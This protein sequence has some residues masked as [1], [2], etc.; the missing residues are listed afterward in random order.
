MKQNTERKIAIM[1]NLTKRTN[2]TITKNDS[3]ILRALLDA[4]PC[5]RRSAIRTSHSRDR[6]LFLHKKTTRHYYRRF[7]RKPKQRGCN[8]NYA[9]YS[10]ASI[11]TVNCSSHSGQIPRTNWRVIVSE[12]MFHLTNTILR[13]TLGSEE[14]APEQPSRRTSVP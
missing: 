12:P 11:N 14:P 3:P 4:H 1:T 13:S 10:L 2:Y 6:G 9:V 5:A 8:Y 7:T